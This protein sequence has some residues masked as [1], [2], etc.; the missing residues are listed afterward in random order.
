MILRV[1]STFARLDRMTAKVEAGEGALGMLMGDTVLVRQAQN[2]LGELTA[3]LEDLQENPQ[4]YVR[5]TIF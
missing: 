2:V 5:L 4:R 1:D 3:F